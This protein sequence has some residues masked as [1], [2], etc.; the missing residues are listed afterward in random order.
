M[1][2][3]RDV[4]KVSAAD[5]AGRGWRHKKPTPADAETG[6][7]SLSDDRVAAR[8]KRRTSAVI[9]VVLPKRPSENCHVSRNSSEKGQLRPDLLGNLIPAGA[10]LP[11]AIRRSLSG[12]MKPAESLSVKE[13]KVNQTV[14]SKKLKCQQKIYR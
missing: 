3:N 2:P 12:S 5:K 13:Y 9:S 7:L 4:V 14:S 10:I 11:R 1:S 6:R 8:I